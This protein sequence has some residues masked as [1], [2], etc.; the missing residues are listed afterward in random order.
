MLTLLNKRFSGSLTVYGIMSLIL[1]LYPL[2]NDS[3]SAMILVTKIFIFGIFAISYDLLLGYT[4]IVSFGHALFFGIGAY[5]VGIM[6]HNYGHSIGVL[7]LAILIGL[8]IAALISYLVGMLSLRLKSHYY[9]MLTLAFAGLF[10][11]AAE[12]WRTLTKGGE[13]FTF[14]IPDLLMDRRSFYW[15]ALAV[16]IV[17]FLLMRRF[18][19]SPLGRVLQAIRENEQRTRSLGF[20]LVHYKVIA[21]IVAGMVAALAGSMYAVTL[22]FVNTSVFS[23]DITLDALLMTI[24]GGVGTLYGGLIGSAIIELAHNGLSNL[25]KTYAIFDRWIIFFG[26]LYIL[27]VMVF[28]LG[29]AGTLRQWWTK[30]RSPVLERRVEKKWH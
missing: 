29:I 5:A 28:P 3:R 9:A 12:K 4:G 17:V 25:A 6:M 22:R 30:W 21:S 26:L 11:V 15:I 16:L 10:Q 7:L 1:A 8:I 13:G 2:I 19:V 27:I 18:T 24:I 20:N 14:T 23:T